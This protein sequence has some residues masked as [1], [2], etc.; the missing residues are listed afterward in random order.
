MTGTLVRPAWKIGYHWLE[1][2]VHR[3]AFKG[4]LF[5]L[6]MRT[7]RDGAQLRKFYQTSQ[8]LELEAII[9]CTVSQPGLLR[10]KLVYR[11]LG[12]VVCCGPQIGRIEESFTND[13][14]QP[15]YVVEWLRH[16]WDDEEIQ[17]TLNQLGEGW[18]TWQAAKGCV[19]PARS[20]VL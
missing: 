5:S 1:T 3:L 20:A 12:T 8:S 19:W 2:M 16:K 18:I 17:A 6:D 10:G 15:S 11:N 4:R 7:L 13:E 9:F 14:G